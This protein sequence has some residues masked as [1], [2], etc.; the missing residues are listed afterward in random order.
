MALA[1]HAKERLELP[2]LFP[3][4]TTFKEFGVRVGRQAQEAIKDAR[5][6]GVNPGYPLGRDYPG[7][8]DAI[9]VAVTERRTVDD[10]ELLAE[11]LAE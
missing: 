4:Q 5:A 10:V 6:Q 2:L 8:D 9:L 1:E 3:E 7:M 11:A